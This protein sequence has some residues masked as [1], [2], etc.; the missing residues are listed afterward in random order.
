MPEC[1]ADTLLVHML[2]KE[3]ANHQ[4]SISGVFKT[5]KS[6]AFKE[7]KAV[8]I[9]DD[10]KR[11]DDY[12]KQFKIIQETESFNYLAHP[13]KLHYLI[14]LK[15]A[16]EGFLTQCG[17]AAGVRHRLLN[18]KEQLKKALKNMNVGRDNDVKDL[19][20]ILFQ[21]KALPLMKIKKILDAHRAP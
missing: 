17:F 19:L 15:P 13:N 4:A 12:Y 16:L 21:K 8:G 14:V 18:N 6:K 5:L 20:N 1:Y 11:K 7:R 10:D 9:I 3:T 2:L